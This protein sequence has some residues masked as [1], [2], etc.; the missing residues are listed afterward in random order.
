M[1][2][3]TCRHSSRDG[4]VSVISDRFCPADSSES[5][6]GCWHRL[7]TLAVTVALGPPARPSGSPWTSSRSQRFCPRAANDGPRTA[8]ASDP[9]CAG[10][11]G[12]PRH[13]PKADFPGHL[14]RDGQP[15]TGPLLLALTA[16]AVRARVKRR[17]PFGLAVVSGAGFPVASADSVGT[18]T[19][20]GLPVASAAQVEKASPHCGCGLALRSM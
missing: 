16:L 10:L 20:N 4:T 19:G 12:L 5:V 17:I 9:H 15:C 14:D 1:R 7:F 18:P 2:T 13:R 6:H 3:S 11:G 8:W